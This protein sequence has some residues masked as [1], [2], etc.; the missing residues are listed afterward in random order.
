MRFLITLNMPA[1][2]GAL[3]HQ[4]VCAHPSDSLDELVDELNR[5]DFIVVEEFYK[6][7]QTGEHYSR[8]EIAINHSHIGKIKVIGHQNEE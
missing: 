8:G 5:N 1:Y 4:V 6:N 3:V 7:P 2:S